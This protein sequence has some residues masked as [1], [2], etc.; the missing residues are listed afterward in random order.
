MRQFTV[1]QWVKLQWKSNYCSFNSWYIPALKDPT[2]NK[3]SECFQI[4]FRFSPSIKLLK[5]IICSIFGTFQSSLSLASFP[6]T[7][8]NR[9]LGSS[10]FYIWNTDVPGT[11]QEA[12]GA[13]KLSPLF[14]C[15]TKVWKSNCL[16]I[17]H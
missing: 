10:L 12:W 17:L 14:P 16:P 2:S 7:W 15:Q 6:S 1:L 5:G 3:S 13:L 8:E 11:R 9:V 4:V